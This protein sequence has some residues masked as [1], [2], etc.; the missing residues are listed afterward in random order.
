M[1]SAP[2]DVPGQAQGLHPLPRFLRLFNYRCFAGL[3]RIELRPLTLIYGRNNAG[4]SALLRSLPLLADSALTA[5]GPLDLHSKAVRGASFH[6]LRWR[7]LNSDDEQ[8][9]GLGLEW[10]DPAFDVQYD[11]DWKEDWKRLVLRTLTVV[12]KGKPWSLEWVPQRQD[13]VS[14]QLTFRRE[15]QGDEVRLRFAGLTPWAG[16]GLSESLN[17]RLGALQ[18]GVQWLQAGRLPELDRVQPYPTGPS[19]RMSPNGEEAAGLLATDPELR[20]QVSAWYSDAIGR[21]L[22]PHEVPTVGFRLLLRNPSNDRVQVDF[23]DV[24]EGLLHALPVLTA[25]AL[26]ELQRPNAPRILA[27]EEPESHLHAQL[28]R[29]LAERLA[30]AAATRDA[31]IVLETHSE[32]VLLTTQLLI[33]RGELPPDRVIAYWVYQ[34]EQGRAHADPVTFD[35]QGR[36]QGNLPPRMFSEDTDLAR[37]IL[38]ARSGRP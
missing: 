14:E 9:I 5:G 37:E 13:R 32:H 7:G 23:A 12:E 33:A 16:Q 30:H 29:R 34:D 25:L 24:G 38:R 15:P 27:V 36:P 10:I 1:L 22:W 35:T 21:E 19:S 3:H 26:I 20:A 31:L 8:T 28:Q 17:Q 11:I 4:K 2:E 18:A 6:D